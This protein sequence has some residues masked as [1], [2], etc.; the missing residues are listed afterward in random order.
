MACGNKTKAHVEQNNKTMMELSKIRRGK[1]RESERERERE[2]ERVRGGGREDNEEGRKK[3]CWL[4][5][6][7]QHSDRCF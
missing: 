1:E 6:K 4:K 5:G 7:G 3:E 2:R